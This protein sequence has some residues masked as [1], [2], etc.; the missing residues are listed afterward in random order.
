MVIISQ[1]VKQGQMLIPIRKNVVGRKT[2]DIH[3]KMPND[4]ENLKLFDKGCPFDCESYFGYGG[5]SFDTLN[6]KTND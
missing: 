6:S 1:S 3:D 2:F 5:K 4:D